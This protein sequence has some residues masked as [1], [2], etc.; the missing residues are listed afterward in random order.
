MPRRCG[1]ALSF[2]IR[3]RPELDD[4]GELN[5]SGRHRRGIAMQIAWQRR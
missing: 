4:A 3:R 1:A 5:P 2:A